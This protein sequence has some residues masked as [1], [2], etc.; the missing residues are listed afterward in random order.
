MILADDLGYADVGF[1]G[2]T[3]FSTPNID[4]LAESGVRCTN[5]YVSH[6][7]CSPSRAGLL[8]GR[9]QH[10]FGHVNNPK[11]G[12]GEGLPLEEALLP[13]ALAPAGYVSGIVGKWH[14]GDE[15]RFRPRERGFDEFFGFLGGGHDYLRSTTSDARE[16]LVPLHANGVEIPL[17][18][19]LTEQL[20]QAALDFVRRHSGS[21]FFLPLP[22]YLWAR[23][24]FLL[25]AVAFSLAGAQRLRHCAAAAGRLRQDRKGRGV[26]HVSPKT[27]CAALSRAPQP[28]RRA[29]MGGV[30]RVPRREA[31]N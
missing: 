28:T 11:F 2:L 3:D 20:T 4:R 9:Y 7:F 30:S 24:E 29:R 14:L 8:T 16:Y 18:G 5:G 25:P 26:G 27:L 21:P 13:E 1:Q 17:E 31:W 6:P 22:Q 12:A 10:R 15:P 19:Y 23:S